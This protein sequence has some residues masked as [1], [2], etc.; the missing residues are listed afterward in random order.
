MITVTKFLIK[1]KKGKPFDGPLLSSPLS[2]VPNLL[3]VNV[4]TSAVVLDPGSLDDINLED[5]AFKLVATYLFRLTSL[6]VKKFN[7]AGL[8]EKHGIEE[9]GI[10]Y[11]NSRLL[12]SM[13]FYQETRFEMTNLDSHG[14]NVNTLFYT[15]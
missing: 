8:V 4:E 3:I 5:T 12:E 11:S 10:T 15:L 9:N 2:K 13:E 14:V 7:K 1:C 6:E